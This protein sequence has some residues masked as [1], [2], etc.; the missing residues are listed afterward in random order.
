MP[1]Q[2]KSFHRW[3]T[4]CTYRINKLDQVTIP[5]FFVIAVDGVM[6][7]VYYA[8]SKLMNIWPLDP[9]RG[10]FVLMNVFLDNHHKVQA[11][12]LLAVT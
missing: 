5:H 8:Y 4:I 1:I 7:K 11:V 2:L 9:I 12:G 3:P 6:E 10:P